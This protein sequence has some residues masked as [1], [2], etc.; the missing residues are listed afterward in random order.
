[1]RVAKMLTEKFIF[2]FIF[3]GQ[4][5]IKERFMRSKRTCFCF[6]K[7]VICYLL[8]VPQK[9]HFWKLSTVTLGVDVIDPS[10]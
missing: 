4:A 9:K 5:F 6:F 7:T 3:F 2:I 1:M 8:S 10:L